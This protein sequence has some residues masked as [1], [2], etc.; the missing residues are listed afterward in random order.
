MGLDCREKLLQSLDE[1]VQESDVVFSVHKR[2]D[3]RILLQQLVLGVSQRVEA[4][5]Q[6]DRSPIWV[7]SIAEVNSAAVKWVPI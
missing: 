5:L 6:R 3:K 1:P 4:V 2:T 7:G